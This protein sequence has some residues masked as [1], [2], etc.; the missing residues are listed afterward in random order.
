MNSGLS[1]LASTR[2]FYRRWQVAKLLNSPE[3]VRVINYRSGKYAEVRIGKERKNILV[4]TKE[5]RLIL[6][7]N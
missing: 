5:P 7:R 3:I 6:G 2:V 1:E 4:H